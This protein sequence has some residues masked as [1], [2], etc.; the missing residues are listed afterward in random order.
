MTA[1]RFMALPVLRCDVCRDELVMGADCQ[2][3]ARAKATRV[4]ARRKRE[5]EYWLDYAAD[6]SERRLVQ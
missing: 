6:R 2:R 3:C 4:A 5:A 1:P